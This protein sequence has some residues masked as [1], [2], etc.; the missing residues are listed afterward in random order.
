[1]PQP[2]DLSYLEKLVVTLQQNPFGALVLL[3]LFAAVAACIWGYR[4]SK[5]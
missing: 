5:T 2:T 4:Q 1:M 3:M